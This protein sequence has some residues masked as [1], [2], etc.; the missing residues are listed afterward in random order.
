MERVREDGCKAVDVEE[1][2]STAETRARRRTKGR[3]VAT[4]KSWRRWIRIGLSGVE[5]SGSGKED[6]GVGGESAAASARGGRGRATPCWM[7]MVAMAAV[8]GRAGHGGGDCGVGGEGS[9]LAVPDLV[10]SER[11]G[12][13]GKDSRRRRTLP[14]WLQA[15]P[16]QIWAGSSSPAADLAWEAPVMEVAGHCQATEEETSA[17]GGSIN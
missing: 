4:T 2:T 10:D 12:D 8:V 6:R 3:L 5:T 9:D 11:P 1:G 15:G 17:V 13:A 7:M 16:V 14:R